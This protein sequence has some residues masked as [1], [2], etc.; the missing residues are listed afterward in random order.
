[1]AKIKKHLTALRDFLG[2]TCAL[3]PLSNDALAESSPASVRAFLL[4]REPRDAFKIRFDRHLDLSVNGFVLDRELGSIGLIHVVADLGVAREN[5]TVAIEQA[6]YLRH[7][8]GEKRSEPHRNPATGAV[9]RPDQCMPYAVEV[10][11]VDGTGAAAGP[12]GEAVRECL[13]NT[14]LPHALGINFAQTTEKSDLHVAFSWLLPAGRIWFG[15]LKK[16]AA[17]RKRLRA[18]STLELEDFRRPGVRRWEKYADAGLH[19]LHGHNG[20]GKSSLAEAFEFLLTGD[21]TRLDIPAP[22]HR[23]ADQPLRAPASLAPLV[24]HQRGAPPAATRHASVRLYPAPSSVSGLSRPATPML[25]NRTAKPKKNSPLPPDS[26]RLDQQ[27]SDRLVFS[28]PEERAKTWL[29]A[30]FGEF[31]HQREERDRVDLTL[32]RTVDELAKAFA[33]RVDPGAPPTSDPAATTSAAIGGLLKIARQ[34]AAGEKP[35]GRRA[36]TLADAVATLPG[37][38]DLVALDT[39]EKLSALHLQTP[40]VLNRPLATD[41]DGLAAKDAL[42]SDLT[43]AFAQDRAVLAR[44]QSAINSDLENLLHRLGQDTYTSKSSAVAGGGH[45]VFNQWLRS[46]ALVDLHQ[47]ALV[48]ARTCAAVPIQPDDPLAAVVPVGTVAT[49]V[50]RSRELREERDRLRDDLASL[51]SRRDHVSATPKSIVRDGELG[52]L[53]KAIDNGV[54]GDLIARNDKAALRSAV[55][56][57][58]P[59][60]VGNLRVGAADWTS[61]LVTAFN[62]RR[63][64]LDSLSLLLTSTISP[65]QRADLVVD[66]IDAGLRY[67]ALQ[68]EAASRFGAEL[69]EHGLKEA[70]GEL[71]A[72]FT[73]ARWAYEPVDTD[74][75]DG[76]AAA[77]TAQRLKFGGVGGHDVA[78]VLNTAER[79]TLALVLYLLCA[80]RVEN[81]YRVVFLDD[82]LQN[83]DEL[84]VTCVARGLARLLRLWQKQDHLADWNLVLLLHGREDCDRILRECAAASYEFPWLAPED[85]A[86]AARSARATSSPRS[87][88]DIVR[89]PGSEGGV[90]QPVAELL[91]IIPS[92]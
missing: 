90:L 3:G 39:V 44:W 69:R 6:A 80:P 23:R 22:R 78:K 68:R 12:V 70:I 18:W 67:V 73:P 60:P 63:A 33:G 48:L 71:L 84:T 40:A 58:R 47:K 28:S 13:R 45:G 52:P 5:V 56:A 65:A 26:F 34:L 54:F 21:S 57:R 79:N 8:L 89:R 43:A 7:L 24:W 19:V 11:F 50:E 10:V 36:L 81:P 66:A 27:L 25:E 75:E 2:T 38:L 35:S 77:N 82:P 17:N 61:P 46:V 86:P 91:E 14:A 64:A 88:E 49:L 87:P 9:L 74:L 55:R 37:R 30:F 20:S 42:R 62:E 4:A 85:L 41:G 53:E 76:D 32:R 29:Q 72:L 16:S 59:Q 1:M 51:H 31:D 92:R 83:M 15:A